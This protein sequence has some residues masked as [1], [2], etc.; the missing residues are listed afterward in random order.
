M[1]NIEKNVIEDFGKEWKHFNQNNDIELELEKLFKNYFRIFPFD[2]INHLSE[3]FD[4]GCGTGR[5]AR[6]IAPKVKKLNCI[7]PSQNALEVAKNNLKHYGNCFFENNSVMDNSIKKSSQDFG[8]CLGV[9]HHIPD[10][11]SGLEKCVQ[12]LKKGAPLLLYLYY[13]FDNK[14][15]WF[16]AIWK[17]SDF[18]RL[19]ISKLPFRIKLMLTTI[20]A[21][22]IYYPFAKL[23]LTMEKLGF[24]I[25]NI[26]ISAYKNN[27]L[28][29]MKTDAL[30]RFGTKLEHRFTKDEIYIMM[31][32]SG[33]TEIR[34]S[35]KSPFWVA[36]GIKN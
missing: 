11:Y 12:K 20:I 6:F 26:P 16:V 31:R 1:K 23:S 5:W 25:S 17:L 27:S 8:Y 34:F 32:N 28:Y 4:M 22:F 10:T 9:L 3:G 7:D 35:E 29:T 21:I 15:L 33:L 18:L 30:D 13:R 14:P 24:D 2:K 19:L 36:V